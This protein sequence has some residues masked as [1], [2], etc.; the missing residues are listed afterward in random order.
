MLA[1]TKAYLQ[2]VKEAPLRPIQSEKEL[3]RAIEM[4]D[5]LLARPSLS[6]DEDDYL[7]VLSDLVYKYERA[8]HPMLPVPDSEML[9]HLMESRGLSRADLHRQTGIP[10]GAIAAILAGQRPL[11][12]AQV[13]TLSQFFNVSSD[14]FALAVGQK[15]RVNK[16]HPNGR[17]AVKSSKKLKTTRGRVNGSQ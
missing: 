14:A 2:L 17:P 7:D 9:R 11:S 13:S 10:A 4:I 6:R 1:A 3:N 12:R 16:R 5:A 15:P 8:A